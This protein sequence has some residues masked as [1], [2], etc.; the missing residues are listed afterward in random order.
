MQRLTQTLAIVSLTL[1]VSTSAAGAE[2]KDAKQAEHRGS[3]SA[4]VHGS[5]ELQIV[6]DA[7][8]LFLELHSPAMNL[9]GFEHEASSPEQQALVKSTRIKLANANALF[10]FNGGECTLN[11]QSADFSAIVKTAE[12]MHSDHDHSSHKHHKS[13]HDSHRDIEAAYQYTCIK[14]DKLRSITTSLHKV[15]PSIA[16]LQVQWIVHNQQG[17]AT[18]NHEHTEIHFR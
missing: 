1:A 17:A 2:P 13:G 15:F 3:Q 11:Q 7:S 14:P 10:L 4:H 18:L 6:L 5:A 8:Q 16:S 9:L 12:N